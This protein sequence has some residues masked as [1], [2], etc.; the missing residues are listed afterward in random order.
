MS[1]NWFKGSLYWIPRG[2][3]AAEGC[4]LLRARSLEIGEQARFSSVALKGG[5]DAHV[6]YNS[7]GGATATTRMRASDL[8]AGGASLTFHDRYD[9]L[10]R[11][12]G[13]QPIWEAKKNDG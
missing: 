12:T 7:D 4:A 11:W 1:F 8:D 6:H 13:T 10:G 3:Q 5:G 9:D 2:A